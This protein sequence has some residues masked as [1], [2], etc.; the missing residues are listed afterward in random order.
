MQPLNYLNTYLSCAT[1]SPYEEIMPDIKIE[2]MNSSHEKS[3]DWNTQLLEH[4][5]LR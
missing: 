2:N 1:V 5:Q 4:H 3:T